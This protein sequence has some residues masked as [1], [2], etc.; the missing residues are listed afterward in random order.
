MNLKPIVRLQ[1][2]H[3]YR[4]FRIMYLIVYATVALNV[5]YELTSIGGQVQLHTSGL[6]L[7]TIITIFIAGLNC[8]RE[9][10]PFYSANGVSRHRVFS[11]VVLSLGI[12][13]ACTA[14]IDTANAVIFSLFMDYRP[15]YASGLHD[16]ASFSVTDRFSSGSVLSASL[17]LKNLLWSFCAYLVFALFGLFLSMLYYRMNRAQKLVFS[18]G[19]PVLLLV[20]LPAVDQNITGGR[21][22]AA[23]LSALRWWMACMMNPV[24]D[25]AA[26]LVL[27]ALLAGA[28]FLL[29]RRV[30]IRQS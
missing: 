11:G 15:M 2:R 25:F 18:A 13:A 7:A 28:A 4:V 8:F 10:F 3:V 5:I 17:L 9:Y 19:I 16:L 23:F 26:H 14:L 12:T 22:T 20:V 27:A 24:S 30:E 1:L 21:I 29:I 6:E